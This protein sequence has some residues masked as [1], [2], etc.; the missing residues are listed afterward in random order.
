MRIIISVPGR[1]HSFHV[2]KRLEKNGVLA[3]VITSYPKYIVKRFMKLPKR[4][5]KSI[6]VKEILQRS[7]ERFWER[8]LRG[9]ISDPQNSINALF[10]I[11]A[12]RRLVGADILMSYP[13]CSLCSIK[14]AKKLGIITVIDQINSHPRYAFNIMREEFSR[15]GR[16][17]SAPVGLIN[18]TALEYQLADYI[19]VPSI[20]AKR[21][22]SDHIGNDHRQAKAHRLVHDEAPGL[23]RTGRQDKNVRHRI[24]FRYFRLVLETG[25][26]NPIQIMFFDIRLQ[27]RA[28]GAVAD[29]DK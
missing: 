29:K 19:L 21:T 14:K 20:F 9:V 8:F 27:I 28:E 22:T 2:A 1:F 23:P 6:L 5:I 12:S 11:I 24:I 15:L 16:N 4:K 13:D 26:M 17:I 25:K 18:R 10:D 7:V 3:E